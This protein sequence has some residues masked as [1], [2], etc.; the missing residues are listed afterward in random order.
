LLGPPVAQRRDD[1]LNDLERRLR[2]L[3]GRVEGF[4]F[5]DLGKNRQ[6]VSATLQATQAALRT[7][8]AE[9]LEA[10]Q[11]ALLNVALA[12]A[13][14]HDDQQLIF[15]HLIDRFTPTHL[16]VLRYFQ[17][18]DQAT[19]GR[20]REQEDLSNQAV[21]DL[22]DSGLL[23]DTRPYIARNRDMPDALVCYNWEVTT[24][25][26]HFLEFIRA[27]HAGKL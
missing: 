15:L 27:P 10:L 20:F 12:T 21:R 16:Q 19:L 18:R 9:K 2:D 4:C 14:Q 17:S 1:W 13:P 7:H 22:H 26:K 11:N 24:L 8:Q 6:F 23:D 5:D 25:G 3:E